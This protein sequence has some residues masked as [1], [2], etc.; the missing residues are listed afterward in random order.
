MISFYNTFYDTFY[1]TFLREVTNKEIDKK[2]FLKISAFRTYILKTRR[3]NYQVIKKIAPGCLMYL[4]KP[5]RF[6]EGSERS[7]SEYYVAVDMNTNLYYICY[8]NVMMIDIDN[9]K[10]KPIL[11]KMKWYHQNK[12]YSFVLFRSL[13]GYHLFVM[14]K[15]MDYK[16]EESVELMLDFNADINYILISYIR[17]Y[18]VRLNKKGSDTEHRLYTYVCEVGSPDNTIKQLINL[19]FDYIDIFYDQVVF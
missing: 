17:G 11:E 1:D 10:L 3:P 9:K 5:Q 13:N 15:Y 18:C 14:N 19:Q 4:Q 8:K 16:S 12:G 7:R 6:I 2:N